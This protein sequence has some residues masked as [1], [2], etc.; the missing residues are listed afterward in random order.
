MQWTWYNESLKTC[1]VICMT[2][3]N[4]LV[5]SKVKLSY[6]IFMVTWVLVFFTKN[7]L[8]MI[9]LF[10]LKLKGFSPIKVY[11]LEMYSLR[12]FQRYVALR[13]M[14]PITKVTHCYLLEKKRLKRE[15]LGNQ[16]WKNL[17]KMF[18]LMYIERGID[19]YMYE[20]LIPINYFWKLSCESAFR[21]TFGE[22]TNM[23][24]LFILKLKKN[25]SGSKYRKTSKKCYFWCTLRKQWIGA[26]MKY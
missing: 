13:A 3:C 10:I 18:L 22:I 17:E 7:K 15:Y 1:S 4:L 26:C 11:I 2:V 24:R 12:A 21:Y 5:T 20:M 9:R 14:L 25:I 8:Y 19:W 23:I 6:C 16:T